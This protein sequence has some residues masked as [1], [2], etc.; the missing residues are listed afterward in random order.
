M[1]EKIINLLDK[2]DANE[3][4]KFINLYFNGD[5]NDFF[6]LLE[7]LG[8]MDDDNVYPVLLEDMP[9]TYLNYRY[10]KNPD[11]TVNYIVDEYFNDVT[12]NGDRL[13]LQLNDREDLSIFFKNDS[14]RDMSSKE[15]AKLIFQEDWF[16]P[17]D[18]TL[19]DIYEE[20]VTELS[21]KNLHLLANIIN[22][23]LSNSKIEP[24]TSLLE[25][26]A[27]DQGHP[28]YVELSTELILETIFNDKESTKFILD[29]V[30]D[31]ESELISLHNNAY[32]TSYIDEK[33]ENATNELKSL[34]SIDN[35]GEWESRKVKRY[36]GEE[37]IVNHYYIDVT[38]FVPYV[39]ESVFNDE[40][41][42]DDY[43]NA[44]EY[45]GD[46]EGLVNE[47]INEDV[48][49]GGTLSIPY[50]DYP[51]HNRVTQYLNDIFEDYI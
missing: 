26:I 41:M 20:V 10:R 23:E 9:M 37:V 39:I 8:I 31:I 1:K 45:Y 32:N 30:P 16:E 24:Q 36:N 17:F 11:S 13:I 46:F 4:Y 47:V 33:W 5:S 19:T 50:Y 21:P 51:D 35:V 27:E 6:E 43:R 7:K 29:E 34:L 18:N 49:E 25:D 22:G 2:N 48:I 28:E 42:N 15:L 38:N 12:R 14:S 40:Y 3:I 44:F